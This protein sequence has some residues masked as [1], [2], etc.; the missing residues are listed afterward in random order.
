MRSSM[1]SR[2]FHICKG[3]RSPHQNKGTVYPEGA[4]IRPDRR[5]RNAAG[6]IVGGIGE[7]GTLTHATPA[8]VGVSPG[9]P[10][11]D[12]MAV[13]IIAN[14]FLSII[15]GPSRVCRLCRCRTSGWVPPAREQPFKAGPLY[16][17]SLAWRLKANRMRKRPDRPKDH[18]LSVHLRD[19]VVASRPMLPN[20]PTTPVPSLQR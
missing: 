5:R 10:D 19:G 1:D 16:P 6:T 17:G 13:D 8:S 18:R 14:R 2:L 7:N 12:C 9:T 3:S 15:Q 4:G 11:L 20:G